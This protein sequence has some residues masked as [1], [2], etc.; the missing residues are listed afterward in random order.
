MLCVWGDNDNAIVY[1]TLQSNNNGYMNNSYN[2]GSPPQTIQWTPVLVPQQYSLFCRYTLNLPP[3]II[4]VSNYPDTVGFGGEI[5]IN[6]NVTDDKNNITSVNVNITYPDHTYE[7]FTMNHINSSHYRYLFTNTW[8]V[9]QY[10]YTIWAVDNES[11]INSSTGHHFHVSAEA[12]I[13]V[14]TLSDSYGPGQYI[15]LTDP[16]SPPQDYTLVGRGQ[17]WNKY[18]N[19]LTGCTILDIS[20]EPVNY[21]NETSQWTPINQTLTALS[22]DDPAYA[23]GYRM[24]ND[25]GNYAAYFKPSCQDSW[26]VAFA[27]NRSNDPTTAVV[28]SQLI[29]VGY[30]DPQDWSYHTLQTMQNSQGQ[31]SDT[32]MTYSGVFP[33]ADLT[34]TYENTRLKE[35]ITLSPAVKALLLSHPPSLYGLSERS[36]LVFATKID[37]LGLI[38]YDGQSPIVGNHTVIQGIDYRDALGRFACALPLGTVYEQGDASASWPLVSRIVQRNGDTYL[39]SGLPVTTLTSMTFPIVIDPTLTIST[40]SSD[41]YLLTTGT[42]YNTVRTATTSNGMT[43]NYLIAIGQNKVSTT[44][45][46]DR[47]YVYFNTSALPSNAIIESATLSLY[48]AGDYSATDFD[49]TVQ[50][51]QPTYPHDPLQSSDY[52]QAYYSGNGGTLNTVSL[53][54]GYNDISL[55]STGIGWITPSGWTKLC[56]RSSRDINGNAPTG[57]EYASFYASEHGSAY[58]PKLTIVFH[59]QSKINNSGTTDIKGYLLMQVQFCKSKGEWITDIDVVNET[60]T[61][62]I[63]AGKCLALDTIFNGLVNTNDL[64][65]GDGLYRVYVALR[66]PEGN[67]LVDSDQRQLWA[68]GEFEVSGL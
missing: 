41:G 39:L 40:S 24:G 6:A 63:M 15:N 28:R 65:N 50:N 2:F 25:H 35:A 66:D 47:G 8:S 34:Y 42:N 26:P 37:S 16:P 60:A 12:Q 53:V 4:N 30:L 14:A 1:S 68:T 10:N 64:N 17:N 11:N 21:R 44:Y 45:S 29:M 43:V 62:T 56:L 20:P 22:S 52:N 38:P 51:G 5:F 27:Y 32:T 31:P 55:N 7:N 23:Y 67:I 57:S 33:G 46:I 48:K 61:R 54:N 18:Y 49:I 9:G 3:E 59:N 36:L 13:S 58:T 19:A